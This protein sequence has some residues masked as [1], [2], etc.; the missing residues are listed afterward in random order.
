L[1]GG[2]FI[3]KN[4]QQL[5]IATTK[6]PKNFVNPKEK[7]SNTLFNGGLAA[8]TTY[9]IATG[10]KKSKKEL[11]AE[12]DI[13]FDLLKNSEI[14]QIITP[15]DREVHDAIVSL[16]VDGNNE[17]ITPLMIYRTMTGNA[18]ARLTPKHYDAISNSVTKC[19]LTRIRIDAKSEVDVY[20]MDKPIY[21]G[22][23]TKWVLWSIN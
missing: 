10:N 11:T 14:S 19:S 23:L 12:V 22:N 1:L 9:I 20:K 4:E 21:E 7:V 13:D 18:E 8:G 2:L 5:T 16:Y 17:Y 6:Y 3:N 15:Y